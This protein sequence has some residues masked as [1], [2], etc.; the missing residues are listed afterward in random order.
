MPTFRRTLAASGRLSGSAEKWSLIGGV[1]A[2]AL[3]V[4]VTGLTPAYAQ[5]PA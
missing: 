1:S 3:V 2:L 5:T 4:S